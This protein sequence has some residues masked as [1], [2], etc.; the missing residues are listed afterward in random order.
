M[1][2]TSMVNLVDRNG[3]TVSPYNEQALTITLD[4]IIQEPGIAYTVSGD[5]IVFAQPPLGSSI[6]DGQTAPGVK[7]YGRWFQF[8]LIVLMRN[9]SRKLK[10][11]SKE[12]ELGLML[13]INLVKTEH[14]FN[15]RL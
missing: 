11:F 14:L 15:L 7:F 1:G 13:P 8:K 3:N 12:V 5:K 2:P 4:G 9:I 10:I 6:K